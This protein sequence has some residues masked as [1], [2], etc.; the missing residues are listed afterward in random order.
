[1]P[2]CKCREP[3]GCSIRAALAR[4]PRHCSSEA[5]RSGSAD[6]PPELAKAAATRV[7]DSAHCRAHHRAPTL[8]RTGGKA[9]LRPG[10]IGEGFAA[11]SRLKPS[12]RRRLPLSMENGRV[13]SIGGVAPSPRGAGACAPPTRPFRIDCQARL[14]RRAV[15]RCLVPSCRPRRV[16]RF[17]ARCTAS[18]KAGGVDDHRGRGRLR[19]GLDWPARRRLSLVRDAHAQHETRPARSTRGRAVGCTGGCERCRHPVAGS[20]SCAGSGGSVGR[21]TIVATGRNERVAGVLGRSNFIIELGTDETILGGASGDQ[22]RAF[23]KNVTVRGGKGDDLVYGGPG[24]TLIGGLGH[25]LLLE[26]EDNGTVVITGK[27]TEVVVSGHHDRVRR[28]RSSGNDIVYANRDTSIDPRCRKVHDRLLSLKTLQGHGLA[29]AAAGAGTTGDPFVAP[30]TNPSAVDCIVN[31]FPKRVL[32]GLWANEYVPAYK[33]PSDHPY[34]LDRRLVPDGVIA[35]K[36]VEIDQGGR[37]GTWAVGIVISG[38]SS[39]RAPNGTTVLT[40][41]HSGFSNST[42]TNWSTGTATYRVILHCTSDQT[43]ASVIA[44]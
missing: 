12:P 44:L 25:D 15:P 37:G 2:P 38:I 14:D 11:G 6:W 18:P 7:A 5:N 24:G 31:A 29:T 42:A 36:G 35:P 8:A 21:N 32:R 1:M 4:P 23:G 30:C 20:S 10:L 27:H 19:P 3:A 39:T 22:I 26:A 43:H 40:G 17:A 34:L 9:G 28:S 41:T 16:G 33:C 13:R